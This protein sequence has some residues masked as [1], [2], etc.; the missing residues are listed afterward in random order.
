MS[1]RIRIKYTLELNELPDSDRPVH[2]SGALV[3]GDAS[4]R[5]EAAAE[6][7]LN[8]YEGT[9]DYDGETIHEALQEVQS[10]IEGGNV[11]PLLD[12]SW[13]IFV[14]GTLAS[15]CLVGLWTE[16]KIPLVAYIMTAAEWKEQ[17]FA[18]AVLSA[19]LECLRE[20]GYS[21]TVA[22][23]TEGNSPSKE[24]FKS[25]GFVGEKSTRAAELIAES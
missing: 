7:M 22:F 2:R 6:L 24:L 5:I 12:C 16:D 20:R 13:Q 17:G 8:A 3:R 25:F 11:Q 15:A 18:R 9:I 10:F 1:D 19:S 4:F 21:Q 14:R 23:I